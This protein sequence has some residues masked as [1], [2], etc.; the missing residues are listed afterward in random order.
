MVRFTD[1][2][3]VVLATAVMLLPDVSPAA[4]D[5][6]KAG[7]GGV[8][9]QAGP[10][11]VTVLRSAT[12][13]YMAVPGFYALAR[14]DVLKELELV[15]EQKKQ[16]EEIGKKY[17]EQ[18]REGSRLNW[19]EIRKLPQ[20]EQK[21]K[22]AEMNE[23]R[24]KMAEEARKQVEKVLLPHQLK[25]LKEVNLRTYGVWMLYNARTLDQLEATDEQ[26]EKLQKIREEMQQKIQDLQKESFD[27]S[28]ELL[29]PK[30]REQLE[31]M[32]SQGYGG[33]NYTVTPR[34]Q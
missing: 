13:G 10:G 16:L 5:A 23:Q 2:V 33:V 31:E 26:K 7:P 17:Y 18:L 29:T 25:T 11:G 19:E 22:Y 34:S 20:E 1:L 9:V 4:E 14:P 24:K 12:P 28:L 15:G 8:T 30:Q 3:V 32:T 6:E 27:K 21:A